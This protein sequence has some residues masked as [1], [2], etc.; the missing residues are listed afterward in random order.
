[1]WRFRFVK[2][3]QDAPADFFRVGYDD[4]EWE[5]FPV[6]GLF[7]LNGH[8]D[9]I[10]KNIGYAIRPSLVRRRTTRVHTVVR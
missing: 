6:P 5:D 4:S 1:M 10:Y 2:N 7:E 9:R 8:G 3:H